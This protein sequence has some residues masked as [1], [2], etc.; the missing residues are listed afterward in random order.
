[1]IYLPVNLFYNH[2]IEH[3][4]FTDDSPKVF[5]IQNKKYIFAWLDRHQG[6]LEEMTFTMIVLGDKGSILR[7]VTIDKLSQT[8]LFSV[9]ILR[10]KDLL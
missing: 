5:I 10:V 6:Y 1:M 8:N 4:V 3:F 9:A 7:T 2:L